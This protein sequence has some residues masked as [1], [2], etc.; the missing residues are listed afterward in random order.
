M[1]GLSRIKLQWATA[2][3]TPGDWYLGLVCVYQR[4][5]ARGYGLALS[6]R[7]FLLWGLLAAVIAYFAGAGYFW[8]KQD[9]RPY[10]FVRYTDVLLY[11][12]SKDKR[13]EVR[14]LQGRAMIAAGLD[15]FKD[16]KFGRALMSLRIGLDRYPQDR[17]AR[18]KLAQLFLAYRLRAKAQETLM[19]GLGYGWPGRAYL[20]SAIE[21]AGAGEDSE[22]VV[23]ICDRALALHEPAAHPAE[24][25]RWLVEQRVR[26]LLGAKRAVEALEYAEGQAEMI[27]EATL[28]ELR[29]VTL[30]QSDR[31]AEAVSSAEDRLLRLPNDPLAL[32]LLARAYREAGRPDDMAR[33]LA[34]IRALAPA[35]P[36]AQIYSVVQHLL[37]G[38]EQ[39]GRDLL[40]DFI[41]RFGGTEE[42]Y[43]LA[44]QP[45]AEI[46]RGVELEMLLAA[47]AERGIRDPRL[48]A[49]RLDVLISERRWAEALRQISD[50][51]TA[52]TADAVSRVGLLDLFQYLV[53]AASDPA[54]GA[55]SNLTDHVRGRQLPMNAYR[56]CIE[57][58][59]S[60]GRLETALRIANFA[61]PV[62]PGNRYL[63]E[64]RDSLTAEIAT[65]AAAVA[66]ARPVVAP[67]EGFASAAAFRTK[68]DE[69]VAADGPSAGLALFRGLRQ[70][71][72]AWLAA[73]EGA[74][75][76]RELELHAAGDDL[77]ELQG[78]VRR[79]LTPERERVAVVTGLATG[80]FEQGKGSAAR[81]LLNEILRRVPDDP[82]VLE[83]RSRWFPPQ[84]EA[85]PEEP[86]APADATAPA[87]P[88]VSNAPAEPAE[89]ATRQ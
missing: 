47:A 25:R 87:A 48:Y 56:R 5:H 21:L 88:A 82:T 54:D 74:L 12:L 6:M 18:L 8:W 22:L 39:A 40:D 62:F 29:I 28:F 67:V 44:A 65:R 86:A 13:Q 71:R 32:R 75:A 42:N 31:S 23:E 41:F 4:R 69:T 20:K 60:A 34:A 84:A 38:R 9:Q 24:D 79:Y 14:E 52:L 55:Q 3:T 51:R 7:G 50:L 70:A 46:G 57:V 80:L 53:A 36:R 16:E 37:A 33:T 35:D 10:N 1:F 73:E 17:T 61:E 68:L 43:M 49:A 78:A 85:A 19:T 27:D 45:L 11:P 89:P 66:A 15:E 77:T 59:R 58:L 26:A 72:P 30:L 76:R 83:L 64:T 63:R 81:L 2:R